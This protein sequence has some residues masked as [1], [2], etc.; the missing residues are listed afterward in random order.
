LTS[1]EVRERQ[2]ELSTHRERDIQRAIQSICLSVCLSV[3]RETEEEQQKSF[4]I[5]R[6]IQTDILTD[7]ET[8]I[9]FK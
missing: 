1:Q 9:P 6:R 2:R 7:K 5:D 3:N 4:Y 8:Y